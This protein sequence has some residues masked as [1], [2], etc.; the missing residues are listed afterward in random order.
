VGGADVD[1]V[2]VGSG[3]NGLAAAITLAHAGR[4]VRV[5]EA[6]DTIGGGTRTSE[7]TLPGYRHDVCSAMHPLAIASPVLRALPLAEHGCEFVQPEVPLA[8]PLDGGY[9]GVLRRSITETAEGL[10]ADAA[11]YRKLMEPTVRE[12]EGIVRDTMMAPVPRIPRHPLATSRFGLLGLRPATWLARSRF[13]TDAGRALFAGCSAH[14]MQPL[15]HAGTAAFGLVLSMLGHAVGW[16]VARGGSQAITDAMASLL[17]SLGGEIETGRNVTS[18]SDLLG[19]R[20]VL[21]DISPRLVE[22]IAGDALP[23]RYRRALRG[24][25][26]GPGVFKI[27]Y[28]LSEPVPWTAEPCRRAGTVHL[29]GTLDEIAASESAVAS[30]RHAERPFVLVGQQSLIDPSRAPEGKH[31][32][33]AYCHVPNGS[34]ADM[35]EAIE[36]QLER[37]APGFR[38]IVLARHTMDAPEVEAYNPSYVGGDINSGAADL[39]Q[40]VRRPSLRWAPST[41]PNPRLL[42]CGAST[43]PG[44]G[45][46]GICGYAAARAALRGVL[47]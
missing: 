37:F 45:V 36:R 7:L 10:G 5:L 29:G 18:M 30:G 25:R 9:A 32:L 14:A 42:L 35:T 6:A 4:S 11:A 24:F 22:R 33:W 46:H 28:A 43:P 31:T 34:D 17:I 12:W 16:P 41:T 39:R 26:Y 3:P 21:F 40:L 2:V 47:R 1:A 23:G 8:H 15:E 20:A 13:Q 27:D 44:G 19:A 38:D